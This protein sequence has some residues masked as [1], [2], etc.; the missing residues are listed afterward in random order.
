V[1]LPW[2]T[3]ALERFSEWQRVG[4]LPHA[5][6]VTAPPGWGA[7]RLVNTLAL[8]LLTVAGDG[9]ARS[10]A[11]T[12]LRWIEP[13]G[14]EIK[15]DAV[16]T[17]A[18]FAVGTPQRAPVKVAVVEDAEALNVN[19]ANALLKTLEEPP[20]N[21]HLL[22]ASG[23]PGRLLPTLRS[24]CQQLP[25]R[26]SRALA[27]PWLAALD[28]DPAMLAL[29]RFELGDAPLRVAAAIA[30]GEAN[31]A[32]TLERAL[33]SEHPSE[34]AETLLVQDPVTV[35]G[36]WLRHCQALLAGRN[37]HLAAG[38]IDARRLF[39]FVDE[40][41]RSRRQLQL[42]NSAN[43]RQLLERLLVLWHGLNAG[44]RGGDGRR[45]ARRASL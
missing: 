32:P 26:P 3:P 37:A 39:A 2:H 44:E 42:S 4:R 40:L 19:A 25:V 6:L 5:L 18:E 35:T 27:E 30:A 21:T 22:L 11:H 10:L 36:R 7:T 17:L 24:R 13:D 43:A 34:L 20:P 12:D 28:A 14:A 41:D 1:S 31:L 33:G 29:A 9:D 16:R 15:V 23:A 45:G 38:G 8:R